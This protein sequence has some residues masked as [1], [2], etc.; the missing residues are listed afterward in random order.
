LKTQNTLFAGVKVRDINKKSK[1]SSLVNKIKRPKSGKASKSK[2]TKEEVLS[3]IAAY[4]NKVALRL[5]DYTFRLITTELELDEYL[6]AIIENGEVSYDTEGTGVD[7]MHDRV[8]GLCLHTANQ[9]PVYV[10]YNHIDFEYNV[11]V[12]PFLKQLYTLSHSNKVEVTMANAMYD[13]RMTKRTFGMED[14]IKCHWDVNLGSKFLN[15]NDRYHNLKFLWEKYVMR[16]PEKDIEPDS[17]K[18]LFGNHKIDEFNPEEIKTYPALDGLMTSQLR[19]FQRQ[20]LGVNGAKNKQVGLEKAAISFIMW[21]DLSE[22]VASMMDNGFRLDTV[23]SDSSGELMTAQLAEIILKFD[24]YVDSI[25]ELFL[26]PL[27]NDFPELFGKIERPLNIGS[28]TQLSILF[29]DAMHLKKVKG[30]SVDVE[31]IERLTKLYPQYK[32]M[33][34][35]VLDFRGLQKLNSTYVTGLK[36]KVNPDTGKIH[37]TLKPYGA[38]TGRFS[39]KNPNLQNIPNR[40]E[41]GRAIRKMFVPSEGYYL[42]GSDYS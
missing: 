4:T 33:F 23:A 40:T 7:E 19:D 22:A 24:S 39:S 14:Y 38:R 8:V 15:E 31:A 41:T 32:T 29:Y 35:I 10:S 42:L 2:I 16:T 28:N 26:T 1:V 3:R 11:N 18:K 36:N 6:T 20:Y 30:T 17:F 13:Q 12:L 5:P 9:D 37:T 27:K 21:N 34:D 25:A